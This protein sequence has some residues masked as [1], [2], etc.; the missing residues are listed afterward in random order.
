MESDDSQYFRYS[1]IKKLHK[2]VKEVA[3]TN[4]ESHLSELLNKDENDQTLPTEENLQFA[5]DIGHRYR[6]IFQK[7]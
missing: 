6:K 3:S 1:L 5:E 4:I 2:R 7:K